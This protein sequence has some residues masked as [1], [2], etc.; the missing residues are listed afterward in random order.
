MRKTTKD[1]LYD[2]ARIMASEYNVKDLVGS[3]EFI[4]YSFH[5]NEENDI[6]LSR[7][8][9]TKYEAE[10]KRITLRIE[11]DIIEQLEEE[12]LDAFIDNF[13][14]EEEKVQDISELF[15]QKQ[16]TLIGV[17]NFYS[18]GTF[19]KISPKKENPVSVSRVPEY[20][21]FAEG[22]DGYMLIRG[23]YKGL[24]IHE[25]DDRRWKGAAAGWAGWMLEKDKN[26]TDDDRSVLNRMVK[27]QL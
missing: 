26:L 6:E 20:T 16:R 2:L 25:I 14:K 12:P 15:T 24:L 19:E 17:I 11:N 4:E 1:K 21:M 10:L 27:N 7:E 23:E 9:I 18:D 22:E 13:A 3:N 5:E 8:L